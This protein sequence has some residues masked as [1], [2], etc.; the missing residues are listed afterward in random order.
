MAAEHSMGVLAQMKTR[1]RLAAALLEVATKASPANAAKY[2]A[3]AERAKTGEFD[4]YA[5]TYVCPV[6][7]LHSELKAAGFDKFAD[8]VA[9]GEFDATWEE[10]QEW[11]AS[12]EAG[13]IFK[14]LPDELRIAL[15][16]PRLNN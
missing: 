2:R 6:T 10:S 3:F 7:Q 4:D 1:D 14:T 12:A 9:N 16:D 5:S 15:R 8:R 13:E 11:A